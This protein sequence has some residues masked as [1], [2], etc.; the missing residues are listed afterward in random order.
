MTMMVRSATARLVPPG[1]CVYGYMN[2]MDDCYVHGAWFH[3]TMH[4]AWSRHIPRQAYSV[5][6]GQNGLWEF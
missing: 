6:P 4:V 2:E 3:I 1:V 5:L